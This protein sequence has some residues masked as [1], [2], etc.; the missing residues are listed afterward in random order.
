MCNYLEGLGNH[1]AYAS[2]CRCVFVTGDWRQS[3]C[4]PADERS[5]KGKW[6][7]PIF[8][9]VVNAHLWIV[10]LCTVHNSASPHAV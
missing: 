1:T 5:C 9:H 8:S 2:A 7:S 6:I 10:I 3:H 4:Q